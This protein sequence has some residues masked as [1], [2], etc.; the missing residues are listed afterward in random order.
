MVRAAVLAVLLQQAEWSDLEQVHGEGNVQ[1]RWD[2]APGTAPTYSAGTLKLRLSS[3]MQLGKEVV[4]RTQRWLGS[5]SSSSPQAHLFFT[6]VVATIKHF[7]P[8]HDPA[9]WHGRGVDGVLAA[10]CKWPR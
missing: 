7:H 10:W 1:Q 4:C 3:A 2:P 9:H 5:T 8:C 6:K